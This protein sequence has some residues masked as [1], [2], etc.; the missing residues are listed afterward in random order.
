MPGHVTAPVA[1]LLSESMAIASFAAFGTIIALSSADT[2]TCP[3]ATRMRRATRS[4][5]S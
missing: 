4:V 5:W 3:P 1:A 2:C